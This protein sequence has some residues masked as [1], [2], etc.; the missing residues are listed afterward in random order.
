[1]R[2]ILSS[3]ITILALLI[4]LNGCSD[5]PVSTQ[6]E[7]FEAEGII[8]LQSGIIIAEIFRG[9][10]T[11]T[12]SAPLGDM[13][14]G[15][16]VKFYNSDKQQMDPPDN[17][18]NSFSWEI[19]HPAVVDVWQHPGEEGGFE[20]HLEGLSADTTF[21]EFFI[22]HDGHADFRSGKIPVVVE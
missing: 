21:I 10:T 6:E 2:T 5:D 7:H 18:E 8:F 4:I 17:D 11:D 19:D 3:L 15:I 16:D 1:M 9:V 14:A 13:T 20:F 12:L 22:L